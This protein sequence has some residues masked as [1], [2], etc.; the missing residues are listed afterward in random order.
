MKKCR[1]CLTTKNLTM[2]HKIPK[3]QGGSDDI[4][5]M[6]S[7]CKKCNGIKSGLS[8]KQVLRYAQWINYINTR[9]ELKGKHSLG[10]RKS[11]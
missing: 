4:K 9:R 3:I 6:Q 11:K 7:L 10:H 1:Y 8:H 2:D 5:N